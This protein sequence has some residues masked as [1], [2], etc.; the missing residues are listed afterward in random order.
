MSGNQFH[1]KTKLL[2]E[3]TRYDLY[4]SLIHISSESPLSLKLVKN[5]IILYL[6]F[7]K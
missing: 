4:Y 7:I 1:G 6:I 2:D 3:V 5:H